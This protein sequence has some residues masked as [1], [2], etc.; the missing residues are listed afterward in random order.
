VTRRQRSVYRL[1]FTTDRF[2]TSLS[3][4]AV[5]IPAEAQGQNITLTDKRLLG[6]DRHMVESRSPS[7]RMRSLAVTSRPRRTPSSDISARIFRDVLIAIR[8]CDFVELAPV[9]RCR[10]LRRLHVPLCSPLRFSSHDNWTMY[11]DRAWFLRD[12][13][14]PRW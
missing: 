1:Q 9:L 14:W 7:F 13:C 5:R 8:I 12:H 11:H 4:F 10:T 2:R 3:M 6:G